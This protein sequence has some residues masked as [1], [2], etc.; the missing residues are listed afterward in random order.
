MEIPLKRLHFPDSLYVSTST[1]VADPDSSSAEKGNNSTHVFF[2]IT[3]IATFE[4]DLLSQD[5]AG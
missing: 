2:D 5:E 3:F 1:A 4:F